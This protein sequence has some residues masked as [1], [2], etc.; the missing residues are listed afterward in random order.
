[1]KNR[2]I[3]L[4]TLFIIILLVLSSTFLFATTTTTNDGFGLFTFEALNQ[5]ELEK[6]NISNYDNNNYINTAYTGEL[7]AFKV[8]TMTIDYTGSHYTVRNATIKL[9][10]YQNYV[11]TVETS[12]N[13]KST[14][15]L[16]ARV[17]VTNTR[18]VNIA[19]NKW[20]VIDDKVAGT[21]NNK[22]NLGT[23][24][25]PKEAII[26]FFFIVVEPDSLEANKYLTVTVS[27][28]YNEET[29]K[30]FNPAIFTDYRIGFWSTRRQT[31]IDDSTINMNTTS[32][33]IVKE[34]VTHYTEVDSQANIQIVKLFDDDDT[35]FNGQPHDYYKVIIDST[36]D[37][38]TTTNKFEIGLQIVS[39]HGF[40]LYLDE[41]GTLNSSK[42]IP[43]ELYIK[44]KDGS[45]SVLVNNSDKYVIKNINTT[46][47]ETNK[48]FYLTTKS[49]VLNPLTTEEGSYKDYIY[50]HFITEDYGS[51]YGTILDLD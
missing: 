47:N 49:S 13:H 4:N 30:G 29:H 6:V 28:I 45:N 38:A 22:V 3:T 23:F 31:Y 32:L 42:Y 9:T 25:K 20:F 44:Y 16:I 19:R 24:R 36:I 14:M 50:L 11:A 18:N 51:D 48:I 15:A 17:N 33:T 10:D 37:S 2:H 43:Y 27:H 34:F 39:E 12:V 1:M 40:K 21:N 8:G 7:I 35:F 41:S 26:E 46:N 5:V